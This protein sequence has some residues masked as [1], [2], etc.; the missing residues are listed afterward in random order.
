M[1]KAES[2]ADDSASD[3]DTNNVDVEDGRDSSMPEISM[4][5]SNLLF[6]TSPESE[7][8]DDPM[9]RSDISLAG[10]DPVNDYVFVANAFANLGVARLATGS[11]PTA[12]IGIG[13]QFGDPI[14]FMKIRGDDSILV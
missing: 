8:N 6:I 5:S 12:L 13:A 7:V 4:R 1:V 14:P 3:A 2:D 10:I 9:T 11:M